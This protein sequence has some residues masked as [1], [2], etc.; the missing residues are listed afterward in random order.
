MNC[1]SSEE[2][3]G[4]YDGTLP[5]GLATRARAHLAGCP[6]CAHALKILHRVLCEAPRAPSP[7]ADPAHGLLAPL[8]AGRRGH[9][10]GKLRG[11]TL[12]VRK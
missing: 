3:A 12:P 4:L 5:A 8:P 11:R 9:R 10:P 2:L 6:R 7:P 1:L